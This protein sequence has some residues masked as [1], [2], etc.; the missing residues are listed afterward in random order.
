MNY[1]II[2]ESKLN[3]MVD[4]WCLFHGPSWIG[5]AMEASGFSAYNVCQ[6]MQT[7]RLWERLESAAFDAHGISYDVEKGVYYV[8]A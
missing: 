5:D 6:L 7:H 8:V 1:T 2:T 4:D 3:D